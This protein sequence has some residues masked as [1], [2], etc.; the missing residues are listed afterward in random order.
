[1]ISYPH[2]ARHSKLTLPCISPKKIYTQQPQ[3]MVK[4]SQRNPSLQSYLVEY[5]DNYVF[6]K[7]IAVLPNRKK[8]SKVKHEPMVEYG[9]KGQPLQMVYK[10]NLEISKRKDKAH[11]LAKV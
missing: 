9:L 5:L 4:R 8:P 2:H 11:T 7:P 1:M 3:R 10:K 6:D